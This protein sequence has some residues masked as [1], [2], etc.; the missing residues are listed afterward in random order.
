MKGR[1]ITEQRCD[2]RKNFSSAKE[3]SKTRNCSPLSSVAAKEVHANN[4]TE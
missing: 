3:S 2:K 1:N 4:K